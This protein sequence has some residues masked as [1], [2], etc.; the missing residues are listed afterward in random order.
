MNASELIVIRGGGDLATG[1]IQK[2]FR[3]GFRVLVLDIAKPTAIRRSVALCEA[4]YD[5]RKTVE[6]M[7]C[8]LV[9]SPEAASAC[10]ASGEI[11]LL[12]DPQAAVLHALRADAVIDAIIAKQNT[13]TTRA[14][15]PITIGI[16][17]GF[18]A[19]EDVDAVIESKR[20]HDLGRV[21]YTGGA[22]PNTGIPGEIGGRGAE[23]VVHAPATGHLK[24]MRD[25]GTV[26]EPGEIIARILCS[27]RPAMVKVASPFGGL[28]RGMIRDG[29][30][31]G[32][33]MKIADI[34]PR[35]G[36][37]WRTISDK[38]RCIGGGALEAYL[39][40]REMRR[41]EQIVAVGTVTS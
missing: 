5:G 38:A 10:W 18:T 6:G 28:I 7:T 14:M 23:R 13:G 22:A 41:W 35:T 40:I 19:G 15:A 26:T 9:A 34:D 8:R 30:L 25:I 33:G 29:S 4:V 16:G 17:P 2:F 36:V 27:D 20:G 12:V 31:V 24:V 32:K 39:A 21:L 3:A 11:P 37:D 1:V